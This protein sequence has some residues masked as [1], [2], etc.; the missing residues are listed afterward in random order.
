M[1]LTNQKREYNDPTL[2]LTIERTQSF[3][4]VIKRKAAFDSQ[5]HS[6]ANM[7]LLYLEQ[8][9]SAALLRDD[10]LQNSTGVF[11]VICYSLKQDALESMPNRMLEVPCKVTYRQL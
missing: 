5:L 3:F 9:D 7:M 1:L 2:K 6:F 4:S 11:Q 10:S 8:A